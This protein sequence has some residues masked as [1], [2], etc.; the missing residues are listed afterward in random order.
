MEEPLAS[1][2]V[3]GAR[4]SFEERKKGMLKKG[5]KAD[6]VVLSENILETPP[7][8]LGQVLVEQT[9]VD[10]ICVYERH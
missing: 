8:R 1:Y 3:M 4:A 7:D 6:F 5:M 10:G 2:T 9:Y